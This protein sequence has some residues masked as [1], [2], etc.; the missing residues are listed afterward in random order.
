MFEEKI[1]N[2]SSDAQINLKFD[3]LTSFSGRE[4]QI[5]A[6]AGRAE[7][8]FLPIKPILVAFSY[9]SPSSLLKDP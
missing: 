2:S 1:E 4:R 9:P 7:L 3:H 6:Y 5:N 8:L